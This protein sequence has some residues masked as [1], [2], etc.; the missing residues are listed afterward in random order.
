MEND[1]LLKRE[2]ELIQEKQKLIATNQQYQQAAQ[3]NNTR[4]VEINGTLKFIEEIKT[5]ETK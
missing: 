4:I 2:A 5:A 3:S 1:L